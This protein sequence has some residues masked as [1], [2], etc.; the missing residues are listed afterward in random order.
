MSKN[1]VLSTIWRNRDER[2]IDR[3]DGERM[4]SEY[5]SD[6]QGVNNVSAL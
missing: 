6:A 2:L 1:Y 5:S 4:M 3:V